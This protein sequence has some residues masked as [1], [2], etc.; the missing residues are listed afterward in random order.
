MVG[1]M[2]RRSVRARFRAVYWKNANDSIEA[3]AI[4]FANHHGWHDGYLMY[5]VVTRLGLPCLDWIT[6]FE[7]F[8][9]FRFVG[10]MPFPRDSAQIRAKTIRR[11]LKAMR[12]HGRSLVLFPE[13]ELHRPPDVRPFERALE[14]MAARVE[15]CQ[16]I[17]VAIR[18]DMSIHERPVAFLHLGLP[19]EAGCEVGERG[20]QQIQSMLATMPLDE[21]AYEL[22]VSGTRSVNERLVF[23]RSGR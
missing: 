19:L 9:L 15:N 10:G 6:E 12:E 20:R 17:P 4:F 5:H 21:S 23:P 8:P 2:I 18:Y 11:T 16:L 13:G 1:A 7:A 14:W 3:P 22:L